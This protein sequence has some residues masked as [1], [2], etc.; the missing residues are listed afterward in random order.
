VGRALVAR[1]LPFA[2]DPFDWTLYWHRRHEEDQA[3]RW[4]RET[5]R[6]VCRAV[7]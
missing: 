4:F 2:S 1:D 7:D 3:I 5:I 6:E